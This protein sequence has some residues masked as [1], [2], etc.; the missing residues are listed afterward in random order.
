MDDVFERYAPKY[1]KL[2]REYARLVWTERRTKEL[3]QQFLK[4]AERFSLK[5]RQA[6]IRRYKREGIKIYPATIEAKTEQWLDDQKALVSTIQTITDNK[7]EKIKEKLLIGLDSMNP[8]RRDKA[9]LAIDN[10]YLTPEQQGKQN[11]YKVYSFGKHMFRR[12]DQLGEQESFNLGSDVNNAVVQENSNLYLWISQRDGDVRETHRMLNKVSGPFSWDDHP[13][14][15]DKYNNRHQGPPGSDWGCRC[16]AQVYR[17][18]KKPLR[19]YIV[20]A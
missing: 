1:Q 10:L 17:G 8:M 19:N 2:V 5:Y 14:T 11:V 15:I 16:F 13:T 4:Q 9:Q 7:K 18:R 6:L 20:K 12:A 3:D